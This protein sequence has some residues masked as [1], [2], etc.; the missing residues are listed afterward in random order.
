MDAQKNAQRAAEIAFLAGIWLMGSGILMALGPLA[1]SGGDLKLGV[2][3]PNVQV[4]VVNITAGFVAVAM[5]AARAW[6]HQPAAFC[7]VASMAGVLAMAVPIFSGAPA[8]MQ[9]HNL[10]AG[11]ALAVAAALSATIHAGSIGVAEPPTWITGSRDD[12]PRPGRIAPVKQAESPA[13]QS[14]P[15]ASL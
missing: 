13:K 3:F 7:H 14:E 9:Q 11:L 1:W 6:N 4:V 15:S 10:L 12:I 5:A 2:A 8:Y